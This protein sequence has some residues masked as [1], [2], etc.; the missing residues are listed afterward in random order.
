[1]CHAEFYVSLLKQDKRSN[2][3]L[4]S[5]FGKAAQMLHTATQHFAALD[6]IFPGLPS[7]RYEHRKAFAFVTAKL[8][9]CKVTP[10]S[11]SLA[12][13]ICY[14]YAH[15]AEVHHKQDRQCFSPLLPSL[16]AGLPTKPSI[17]RAML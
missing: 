9:T 8:S 14:A 10:T 5:D 3:V 2:L 7:S 15:P 17:K 4:Q 13:L 6:H 11:D 1:M 16:E 12:E